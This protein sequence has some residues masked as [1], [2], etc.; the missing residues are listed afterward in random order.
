[1]DYNNKITTQ[2][3]LKDFILIDNT[4]LYCKIPYEKDVFWT[5]YF[6]KLPDNQR[7]TAQLFFLT[8]D[9]F[10]YNFDEES[11]KENDVLYTT[12]WVIPSISHFYNTDDSSSSGIYLEIKF[13]YD[14]PLDI[15]DGNIY[16][17]GEKYLYPS[18]K[19]YILQSNYI[20]EFIINIFPNKHI[21][22]Q[23]ASI[24]RI[25][26]EDYIKDIIHEAIIITPTEIV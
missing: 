18:S 22:T 26:H 9:G 21:E 17:V 8:S 25:E 12:K 5:N 7:I 3:S 20:N 14:T 15:F 23:S 16:F 11:I 13:V 1:M 24:F 2:L 4:T 19:Y 6:F 10:V